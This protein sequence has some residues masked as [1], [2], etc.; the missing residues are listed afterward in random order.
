MLIKE[1]IISYINP[2][3]TCR[4]YGVRPWQ[5]PQFL[6]L[7]MG[8]LIIA[9]IIATW[10]IATSKVQNPFLVDM[11]V[12]TAGAILLIIS[13]II[14]NSFEKVAEAS[15]MKTEFIGIVSHQL[16]T[17]LT[18]LR[19]SLDFLL[20]NDFQQSGKNQSEY[21]SI[22]QENTKRM[23]DLIDS[24]LTISKIKSGDLPLQKKAIA[25][26]EVASAIIAKANAF[27]QA[28]QIEIVFV[29][30]P[31]NLMVLADSLWLDQIVGNLLDNAIKYSRGGGK[32]EIKIEKKSG[33]VLFS[34]KD[35]GVGI[36]KQEQK[37][38]FEKFFRSK[39]AV[40]KQA[41]GSGLGLHI[42]KK[43]LELQKGKIWFKSQEGKGTTF[44]FTLP[45]A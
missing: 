3:Y 32:V 36:P 20:S 19:F 9:V 10:L 33:K 30:S 25:L 37:F 18:N 28:S 1:K 5:C 4:K 22:L 43:F 8:L 12:L 6:F 29:P 45:L 44:Y 14:T 31:V 39:I 16:R 17:P 24:L 34:I 38:I 42:V 13:F 40:Q 26:N 2:V 21:F 15:R 11:I 7:V 41:D 35:T 27:A 23:S